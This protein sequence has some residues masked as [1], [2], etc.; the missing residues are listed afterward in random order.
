MY[1]PIFNGLNFLLEQISPIS[2]RCVGSWYGFS[3][4]EVCCYY[5]C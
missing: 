5:Y 3:C 4:C 2:P 1:V